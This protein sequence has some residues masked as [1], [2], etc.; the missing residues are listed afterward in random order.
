MC[1]FLTVDRFAADAASH[2]L[3]LKDRS[4]QKQP[5][6]MPFAL[7]NPVFVGTISNKKIKQMKED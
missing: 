7:R 3:A 6:Y 1:P 4:R 5:Y 2:P